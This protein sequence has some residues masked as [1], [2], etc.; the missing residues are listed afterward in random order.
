MANRPRLTAAD[1]IVAVAPERCSGPG[2]SNSPVVVVVSRHGVLRLEYIQPADQSR[3]MVDLF[4]IGHETQAAL[5]RAAEESLGREK[6][7]G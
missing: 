7:R 2:W 6:D 3:L 4:G 1:R 5:M